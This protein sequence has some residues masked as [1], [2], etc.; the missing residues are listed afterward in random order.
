MDAVGLRVVRAAL[1]QLEPARELGVDR[2]GEPL[3]PA[4]ARGPGSGR[5]ETAA[6]D[7]GSRSPRRARSRRSRAGR[8]AS[9]AAAATPSAQIAPSASAPSPSASG[10]RCASSASAASGVSSQTPARF[11]EPAS[12]ST[13]C[14]PPSNASRN[15]G[16]FG[17]FSPGA[18]VA[19]AAR[20]SSGARARRARRPRSETAAASPRRRAPAS[21][22]PSSVESGG[23][24]VFSVATCAG[25]AF[26]IGN[27]LHRLVEL[28][29]PGL[30]LGEL[31]HLTS[32]LMAEPIR[33]VV[34]RGGV[35]EATHLV[36]AVAVR[37]GR[38]GRRGRRPAARHVPPLVGE[39]V[40]G[41]AARARVRRPRRRASSRSP[42]RRTSP[43][44]RSSTPSGCC[45][46]RAH[47][48]EDDLECG[49]EGHPPST[50][51]AQLLGQARGMLA[52]C[53]ARGWRDA[54]ATG[55]PSHRMQ[56]TQPPRRRRRRPSVDEDAIPPAV[57]GCGV[58][59]FALDARA[60]GRDVH[61]A[62]GQRGGEARRRRDARAPGADPRRRTHRHRRSCRRL[63][64][65]VAKG[66]AEGLL[67]GVLPGG[68][69]FAIKSA[70]GATARSVPRSRRVPRAPRLRSSPTLRELP[71]ANSRGEGV[72]ALASSDRRKSVVEIW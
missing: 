51:Q 42:R 33:V 46:R 15:A 2:V 66:G 34:R 12:V 53:R 60:D 20:R 28:A 64:G 19:Q 71:I 69:G 39:A 45:S 59:T 23:S 40:P 37:D 67:C 3:A 7:G 30:H 52:V 55:S 27:A 29:S 14:A 35:V 72:G 25:P 50:A 63:P 11:F 26:T 22:R 18:Q 36:H 49:P 5:R 9:S 41:A 8:G 56:R 16:V 32:V 24:N 4:P 13:S 21:R 54:R 44:A 10:P 31:G 6:R 1:A 61:P 43:T 58:V 57:D 38:D 17:P 65:A 70:D 47:A 68:V 62:R 48:D